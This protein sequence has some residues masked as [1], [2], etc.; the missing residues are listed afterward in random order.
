MVLC[1]MLYKV[2]L[3][4]VSVDEILRWDQYLMTANEQYSPVAA[5]STG[6]PKAQWGAAR[7]NTRELETSEKGERRMMGTRGE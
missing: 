7:D 3:A 6:F 4:C 5:S 1:V 2:I